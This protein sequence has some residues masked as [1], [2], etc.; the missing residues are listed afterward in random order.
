[1]I[2]RVEQIVFRPK[3][4]NSISTSNDDRHRRGLTFSLMSR[5]H[6]GQDSQGE[7]TEIRYSP[8]CK[9]TPVGK[10]IS[11]V[12]WPINPHLPISPK[13]EGV[14]SS[15]SLQSAGH[16]L[17]PRPDGNKT[18]LFRLAVQQHIK[19]LYPLCFFFVQ[20]RCRGNAVRFMMTCS[21][22]QCFSVL[23]S[24]G[25]GGILLET[26]TQSTSLLSGHL[27]KH[28]LLLRS[29]FY[30]LFIVIFINYYKYIVTH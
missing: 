21:R 28:W 8:H 20:G 3:I 24:A 15:G 1:M 4:V 2:I 19:Y 18:R 10:T 7:P 11:H 14:A 25:S 6:L 17:C 16:K 26:M 12:D 13:G 9:P 23:V 27:E 22:P 30:C 29:P 5:A